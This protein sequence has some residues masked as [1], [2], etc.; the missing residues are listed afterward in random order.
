MTL[1]LASVTFDCENP[2]VLARFWAA[3]LGYVLNG[4]PT[5]E[6]AT[7]EDPRG[8]DTE[9]VF[10]RVPESK[11]VKNR[12][13]VDLGTNDMETEVQRLVGLGAERGERI[14]EWTVMRDPEGNEFCVIQIPA[15]DS[16]ESW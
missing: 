16:V 4:E 14:K 7:V 3:A 8:R 5:Q 2:A 13:H 11:T 15:D 10:V 1:R 9:M 6:V 12:V